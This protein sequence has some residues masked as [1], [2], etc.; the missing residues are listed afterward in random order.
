MADL[1]WNVKKGVPVFFTSMGVKLNYYDAYYYFFT[2]IFLFFLILSSKM[3]IMQLFLLYFVFN[4]FCRLLPINISFKNE[5][6]LVDKLKCNPIPITSSNI[7]HH[8]GMTPIILM[9]TSK[10]T[11]GARLFSLLTT[12]GKCILW[13]PLT[14]I[15]TKSMC[16]TS[17]N[18]IYPTVV[19]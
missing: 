9:N 6:N 13:K 12:S 14:K 2:I 7:T 3:A 18:L 8:I 1:P 15:M 11:M 17:V 16:T 5:S 10:W 4:L 19:P